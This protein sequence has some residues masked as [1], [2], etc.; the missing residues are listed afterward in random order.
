MDADELA[1]L[2]KRAKGLL[3]AGDI[4]VRAAAARTRRRRAGRRRR[5]DAGADLRSRRARHVRT[6]ATSRP[7]PTRRATGTSR[8]RSSARPTRSAGSPKCKTD[9]HTSAGDNMRRLFGLALVAMMMACG[10]AARAEEAE[11]DPAKVSDSLKAIFQFGSAADQAG[12]ERQHGD[13]DHRHHRRH[14][15]AVRRRPR[16]RARRRQQ[17]A[18]TAD[19]RARLGAERRRHP[20]PAGRRPRHRARRHA[21]LSRA[22]G[23]RQGHQEAVHLCDQALQ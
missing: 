1:T 7:S 20:V 13:A 10:L 12:A 22:Q 11:Y 21:R 6:S 2:M 15:C 8:P 9:F 23:L 18:R 5:A 16:F 3:A 4:P 17:A 19:R 14:L